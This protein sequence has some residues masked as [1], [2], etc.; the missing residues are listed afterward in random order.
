M[1]NDKPDKP[2]D[3]PAA[4]VTPDASSA[5]EDD[6]LEAPAD[7]TQATPSSE[8]PAIPTAKGGKVG[9]VKKFG[10]FRN[11]YLLVFAIL[12]IAAGAVVYV[13]IKASKKETKTTKVTTLTDQQL[14]SL[15]GNT[16]LVGDAKQTLDIQS[17]TIFEG[18]VLLRADLDV[19][20]TI[21]TGGKLSLTSLAVG[22]EGTF[23][24]LGVNN[25]LNVGGDTTLQGQLTV[26]KNLDVNG[27]ASFGALSVSSLTVS[28]L[29]LR[30]DLSLNRHI[31]TSGGTPGRTKGTAVGGGGT[32]SV[33]GSDTAGTVTINTGS[34]P[35]TGCFIT[36]G[37]K[38]NYG[39]TPHVVI[40]PSNSSSANL[41]YYTN[42]SSTSFS[43]CTASAPSSGTT[44]IFDYIVIK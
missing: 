26:Q 21:K 25:G 9:V 20:G 7:T 6:S 29:Q 23:G 15:K 33:S 13:S 8:T 1:P 35:P 28:T 11:L 31:V 18:Q 24:Q 14:S 34:S 30:G 41:R 22:Q 19:A 37:F 10:L 44:Y 32:A 16:T 12:L 38:N 17:N 3:K 27:T 4:P 39:A 43:V 5:A 40:S 2:A 42:R 36:V